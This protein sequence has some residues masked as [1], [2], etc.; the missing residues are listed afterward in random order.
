[1]KF[2][3]RVDKVNFTIN[4]LGQPM[5]ELFQ[6][7]YESVFAKRPPFSSD[8]EQGSFKYFDTHRTAGE[9]NSYFEN[10]TPIWDNSMRNHLFF[11]AA[12][13]WC[14]TLKIA[15]KWEQNSKSRIHKGTPYYFLGGT[16]ILTRNFDEGFLLMHQALEEDK[17]TS[18]QINP[19]SPAFWFVTLNT[20]IKEQFFRDM[21]IEMQDYLNTKISSYGQRDS[22]LNLKSP[23][24]KK[25]F[26]EQSKILSLIVYFVYLL[27][28][29]Y[30]I[31]MDIDQELKKSNFASLLE[32]NLLFDLCV[33]IECAIKEKSN[34]PKPSYGQLLPEF[35]Q[36]TG[37]SITTDEVKELSKRFRNDFDKTAGELLQSSFTFCGTP[38]KPLPIEED[39][40][41][42]YG[43]RNL[44]A[45]NVKSISLICENFQT[46][47]QRLFNVLFFC[48]EK[49][50]Q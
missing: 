40:A 6:K 2:Q 5:N 1:M 50:Y 3:F 21:T 12:Q 9:H 15:Y 42:S 44:V 18:G 22:N 28:K 41:L 34:L 30:Q 20:D 7:F 8:F 11:K 38:R 32:S 49:L 37:L 19:Q 48:V 47:L 35:S 24:F 31:E 36:K 45:H 14:K 13:M 27:F 33:V 29:F 4:N 46:V 26:L 17:L 43:I 10:F 39:L 23:E 16:E 25:N